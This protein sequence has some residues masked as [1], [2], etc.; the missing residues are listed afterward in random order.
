MVYLQADEHNLYISYK[1]DGEYNYYKSN[2]DKIRLLS[3]GQYVNQEDLIDSI[4]S[5]ETSIYYTETNNRVI[6]EFRKNNIVEMVM[7]FRPVNYE[8]LPSDIQDGFY[9][10]ITGR[11]NR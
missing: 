8:F 7:N 9:E 5:K 4:G 2:S 10:A 1:K 6:A 3:H 11:K